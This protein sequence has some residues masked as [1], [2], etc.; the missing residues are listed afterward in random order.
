MQDQDHAH[1]VLLFVAGGQ[2][3]RLALARAAY[4]APDVALLDDPLSA[5]DPRVGRILF[6]QCIG[7]QGIMQGAHSEFD[8]SVR[9]CRVRY[10]M[11]TCNPWCPLLCC[12]NLSA[13]K[14]CG[15]C[16]SVE[17]ADSWR[18]CLCVCWYVKL[19]ITTTAA[20]YAGSARILITH[21]RQYLPQCDRVLVLRGGSVHAI[22]TPSELAPMKLPELQATEGD[23]SVRCQS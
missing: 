19:G 3:A 14:P 9:V 5:V 16:P 15:W 21:Q 13:V 1:A 17:T 11:L 4:A 12:K 18:C 7:P 6:G 10:S 23:H 20:C 22:G 8:Y 2:K